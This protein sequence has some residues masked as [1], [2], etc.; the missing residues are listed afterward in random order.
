MQNAS[1]GAEQQAG[2][3]NRLYPL[4]EKEFGLY[5]EA[6]ELFDSLPNSICALP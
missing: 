4:L 6:A 3:R 1:G 2:S 5:R